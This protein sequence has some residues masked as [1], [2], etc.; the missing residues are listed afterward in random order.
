MS[1]LGNIVLTGD[2]AMLVYVVLYRAIG[3]PPPLF[4]I[5]MSFFVAACLYMSGVRR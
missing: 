1:E 2:I 4:G 3:Q 5:A